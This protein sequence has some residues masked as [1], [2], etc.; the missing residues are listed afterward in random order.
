MNGYNFVEKE[1][2]FEG[3]RVNCNNSMSY[4]I[5]TKSAWKLRKFPSILILAA[6]L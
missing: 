2:L 4:N 1:I 3:L 6:L 5:E